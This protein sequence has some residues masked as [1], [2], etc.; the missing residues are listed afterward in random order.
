MRPLVLVLTT[1]AVLASNATDCLAQLESAARVSDERTM[2]YQRHGLDPAVSPPARVGTTPADVLTIFKD[3]GMSPVAHEL[4]EIERRKFSAAFTS[5]PPLHQDI[6]NQRLRGVSFVDNMPNTALT[7]TVNPDEPY[8]LFDITIRA[9]ILDDNVSEWLTEKERTCFETKD[10]QLGVFIEAGELDAIAYVLLHEATHIVDASLGITPKI[11]PDGQTVDDSAVSAFTAEIW[12]ERSI[13]FPRFQHRPLEEI[14]FRDDAKVF[15][16]EQAITV[17][18]SLQRTPFVS[19]YG[20]CNWYEDLA[21]FVSVYHF[22]EKLGQRF[23]IV[24]RNDDEVLFS[25]EPMQS[26]LVKARIGEMDRF[27]ENT[28]PENDQ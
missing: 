20:S 24:V 5:L 18:E 22:T 7:S 14:H 17:Y 3:A 10:P 21:E 11:R 23:R 27:Y 26:K 19:L 28:E 1:F 15:P 25:Y 9:N 6:L 4:S 12:M 16:M 13:P 2:A 8:R